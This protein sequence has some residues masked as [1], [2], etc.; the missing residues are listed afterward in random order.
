[1]KILKIMDSFVTNSSSVS[2]AVILGLKKGKNFKEMLRKIGLEEFDFRFE[3]AKKED[4]EDYQLS[5]INYD[6]W[7]KE[8]DLYIVHI[9]IG[10]YGD[11]LEHWGHQDGE[12]SELRDQLFEGV[13]RLPQKLV[14]DDLLIIY[15]DEVDMM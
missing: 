1:M 11:D 13:H 14:N 10:A 8:F 15:I 9:C 4:L 5:E 12:H 2:S 6:E 7:I 3:K